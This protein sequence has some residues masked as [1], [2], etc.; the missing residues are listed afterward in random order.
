MKNINHIKHFKNIKNISNIKKKRLAFKK[1][2]DKRALAVLKNRGYRDFIA[3]V[4]S[5]KQSDDDFLEQ[6]EL[7]YL[8]SLT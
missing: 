5:K 7:L 1:R 2:N 3:K 6:V 8:N 4:K